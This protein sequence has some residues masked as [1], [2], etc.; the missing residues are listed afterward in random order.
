[1]PRT[2]RVFSLHTE[3]A[4]LAVIGVGIK[5]VAL[6]FRTTLLAWGSARVRLG[7]RLGRVVVRFA[8]ALARP[9]SSRFVHAS[10]H[11]PE[12]VVTIVRIIVEIFDPPSL[13][14]VGNRDRSTLATRRCRRKGDRTMPPALLRGE[15]IH[16]RTVTIAHLGRA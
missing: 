15:N 16:H 3:D 13:V 12:P 2:A 4:V 1:M 10:L 7:E 9:P 5:H 14:V 6:R 8:L 11:E